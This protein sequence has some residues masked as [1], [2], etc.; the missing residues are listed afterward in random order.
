MKAQVAAVCC[1]LSVSRGHSGDK[2]TSAGVGYKQHRLGIVWKGL[3]PS[4]EVSPGL[5]DERLTR[6]RRVHASKKHGELPVTPWRAILSAA[7]TSK[8]HTSLWW[9]GGSQCPLLDTWPRRCPASLAMRLT[10]NQDLS[11]HLFLMFLK[12]FNQQNQEHAVAPWT[13]P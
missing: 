4:N 12:P 2:S 8:A 13:V 10:Q 7:E 1:H 9:A 3:T 6:G 11:L 5:E